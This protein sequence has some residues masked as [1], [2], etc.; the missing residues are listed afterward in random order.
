MI[1]H[2][3]IKVVVTGRSMLHHQMFF[4]SLKLDVHASSAAGGGLALFPGVGV[5]RRRSPPP[6][7]SPRKINHDVPAGG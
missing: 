2:R 1:L 4:F 6:A 3:E 7:L 5:D